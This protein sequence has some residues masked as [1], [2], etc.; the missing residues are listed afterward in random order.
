MVSRAIIAEP[1]STSIPISSSSTTTHNFS[2][3]TFYP[4]ILTTL[5]HFK[6][7]EENYLIWQQQVLATLRSLNLTKFLDFTSIPSRYSCVADESHSILSS[8]FRSFD[9]QDQAIVAWLLSSIFLSLLT[10]TVGLF[11]SHQSNLKTHYASRTHAHVK[12]LKMLLCAPKRDR[13]ISTFLQDLKKVVDSLVGVGSL[14]TIEDHIK[15]IVEGLPE[16]Y[17]T[18]ITLVTSKTDP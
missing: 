18:F 6:I 8:A 5:I 12:K 9:Q 2:A 3:S 4:H 16:E 14:I 10:N 11:S 17:D 7:D 1:S 13:S 15:A